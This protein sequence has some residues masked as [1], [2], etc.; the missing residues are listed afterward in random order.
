MDNLT[1]T[2]TF[3]L[4]KNNIVDISMYLICLILII[5][6]ID[7]VVS[8]RQYQMKKKSLE[9]LLDRMRQGAIVAIF[10]IFSMV[11]IMLVFIYEDFETVKR[12]REYSYLFTIAAIYCCVY[13]GIKAKNSSKKKSDEE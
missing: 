2:G 13:F 6:F 10:T 3:D 4:L 7:L 8:I 1:V 9:D 11:L 12:E 5:L